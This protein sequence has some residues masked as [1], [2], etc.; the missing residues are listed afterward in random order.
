MAKNRMSEIFCTFQ[1]WDRL[2]H[3]LEP[4]IAKRGM[5]LTLGGHSMKFFLNGAGPEGQTADHPYTAKK[6]LDYTDISWQNNF[7]HRLS[8]YCKEISTLDRISLWPEDIGVQQQNG[9]AVQGQKLFLHT[10]LEFTERLKEALLKALPSVQ[11][12]HIAYNAGFFWEI[13]DGSGANNS[14]QLDTL[15]AYWGRSYVHP[16]FESVLPEDSQAAQILR[17]VE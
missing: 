14:N 3:K 11:I 1:L 8:A 4:E 16:F 2:R 15:F 7:F 9:A 13:L 5:K 6:Q 10:Y 17:E 12:E